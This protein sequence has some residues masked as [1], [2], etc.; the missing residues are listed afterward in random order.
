MKLIPLLCLFLL[1]APAVY[2]GSPDVFK[3]TI[4]PAVVAI[5]PFEK[6]GWEF[7]ATG[8]YLHSPVFAKH[9]RPTLN[10]AQGDLSLGW[11]WTS[12]SPLFGWD[13][14]RGNWE[15]L[16]NIFYA[17]VTKGPNGFLAGGRVLL[18]YN[19]VQPESKWVPFCQIGAGMLGNN[20]YEHQDQRLI[21]GGFEFTLVADSGL[22]YFFTPKV[23][24]VLMID[25]EHISNANT[26]SRNVGVNAAGGSLGIGYF[27]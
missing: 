4:T 7:D 19:F 10:Y 26:A 3:S 23:A 15:T 12:P 1:G 25:F 20:V 18:R 21:G 2:A 11:M 17:G 24:G 16:G 14:L 27:F 8:G 9:D 13:C 22:R 5:G 6:G